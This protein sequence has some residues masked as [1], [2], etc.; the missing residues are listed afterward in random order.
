[1]VRLEAVLSAL[2]TAKLKVKPR[3]CHLFAN[4]VKFLGHVVSAQGISTD[5]VKVQSGLKILRVRE[6]PM[7]V[8][9]SIVLGS[10]RP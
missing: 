7:Q 6:I 8:R 9:D 5:P 2:R 1:M 4:E 10:K 3:K